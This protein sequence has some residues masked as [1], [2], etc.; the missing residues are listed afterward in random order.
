MSFE[1]RI[2]CEH[3]DVPRIAQTVLASVDATSVRRMPTSDGTRTRLYINAD[4]RS[5]HADCTVC[6]DDGMV[7]WALPNGSEQRR[8][9]T[10]MDYEDLLAAGLVR[11]SPYRQTWRRSTH[12]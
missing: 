11:H 10:G 7:L 1:I 4:H 6:D 8:P 9:C 5:N 2:L 12:D 3:P